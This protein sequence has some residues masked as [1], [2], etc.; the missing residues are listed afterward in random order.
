METPIDAKDPE[1]LMLW[2][3]KEDGYNYRQ[4]RHEPWRETYTLYRD[5]VTV[6]RLTQRQSVNLPLMKTV[7]RTLLKDVDDMPVLYFENLDNDKDKEIFL[8]E[9]WKWTASEQVNNMEVQDIV[10]KKQVGLFGRSFCQWQI[11]DGQIRM[12]VQDPQDILVSR[13]VD[14]T[15]LNSAR[16]LV[17]THIFKPLSSLVNNPDYDQEEVKKLQTFYATEL[18]LIK[19]AENAKMMVEKNQKMQDMGMPDLESPILGET[20]VELSMHF[21]FRENEKVGEDEAL[22][23]QF[24]LYVEADDQVMLMKKP[25]EEVIGTT[26]DHFWRD[27]LPYDSWADDIERQDFWSDGIGDIVRT[28]NKILNS[29]VSQMVENRTL[30]NFGMNVYDSSIEGFSPETFEAV[31]WGWY[32][33]PVP[34][35]KNL[36]QVFQKVEIPDLSESLDE[37]EFVTNFVEKAT[38]ATSTQQGVIEDRQVTLGEIK[39]S[40]G[41]AKERAKGMAKFYVPVWKQRGMIFLKLIEAASEKLDMVKIYKKGRNTSDIYSREIGPKDWMTKSGYQA[42]VWSREEKL[43]QDTQVLQRLDVLRSVMPDNPKLADVYQRK[44]L[45][46]AEV[47]PDDINE[48]MEFEQEKREM[49]ANNMGMPANQ[50]GVNPVVPGAVPRP[51]VNQPVTNQPVV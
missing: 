10:D 9:Y 51:A 3:N 29:W 26:K 12:T 30:R 34:Q 8:N 38:G 45:N 31:P 1:L 5:T 24:F 46:F 20:Y 50:P 6:N 21:V 48:I 18:G 39:L 36:S 41:E 11:I 37:I 40:L 4:R 47:E 28:P 16:S 15:N 25:L 44:L 2:G 35:G 22:P 13:Y 7:I 33:I 43:N 23:G 32:G 14:P 19:Q 17:H 49:M 27:H 42:K